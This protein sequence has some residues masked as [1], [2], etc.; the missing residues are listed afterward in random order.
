MLSK[1]GDEPDTQWRIALL[2]QLLIPNMQYFHKILGHPGEIRMNLTMQTI[3]YHPTLRKEIED[4][5]VTHV[6][7]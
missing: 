3:Y 7:G 1:N 4:L 6:K 5:H 2:R